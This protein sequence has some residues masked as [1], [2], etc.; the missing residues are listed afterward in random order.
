MTK[1]SNAV[2]EERKKFY[3]AV[4][5]KKKIA[6]SYVVLSLFK[7][8][9]LFIDQ[10]ITIDTFGTK[11]WK[12]YF[13][14]LSKAVEKDIKVV[15]EIVA[16]IIVDESGNEFQKQYEEFGGWQTIEDGMEMVQIENLDSYLN[17]LRKINSILKLIKKGFPINQKEFDDLMKKD[18]DKIQEDFEKS[19]AECFDGL[20][21]GEKVEDLSEGLW[22]VVE[23][24][25][26]AKFRGFPYD[27]ELLNHYTNGQ[28]L[29]N[30]TMLSANSGIGKTFLTIAQV[31]PTFLK[32]D[33]GQKLTILANEEDSR[34]W[35]Q[36]IIV[37]V[38]NNIYNAN[39]DKSRFNTGKF[40]KDELSVLK[41]STE[42]LKKKMGKGQIEFVAFTSFSMKKAIKIIK[43]Q[44]KTKDVKYFILDTLKMDS[45]DKEVEQVWL[46]LQNNMVKLFDVVKPQSLNR[47]VF[48]TY[49]LGKSAMQRRY[50]DQSA[51]GV[52]RNVVDVVSVL[53]LARKAWDSEKRKNGEGGIQ[54]KERGMD[55]VVK[56]MDSEKDYFIIFLGKNRMNNTN[57]Q[58]VLEVDMGKNIVK[59][60]GYCKIEQEF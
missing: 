24:A 30:I 36:A 1:T 28:S 55:G 6:E 56:Y 50:L 22:K 16:G 29:G 27:S 19:L 43:K 60:F 33:T 20:E 17:E 23:E 10:N 44:A 57:E 15:D 37:W 11:A 58:I 12:F 46:Q 18:V 9:S 32:D 8:V 14:L 52:S 13:T 40:T 38:A 45:T 5:D 35:K 51:L 41:E 49:Q 2:S 31:F 3:L 53:M 39:F 26:E 48:V 54:V 47:H 42:W 34:K 25:N 4:R 59:D 7:D 21:S